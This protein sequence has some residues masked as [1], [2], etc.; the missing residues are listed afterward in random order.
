MDSPTKKYYFIAS[1]NETDEARG[2]F[3]RLV[4]HLYDLDGHLLSEVDTGVGRSDTNSW[5]FGWDRS[6]DTIIIWS[7]DKGNRAYKINDHQL[8]TI[9][10]NNEINKRAEE[11]KQKLLKG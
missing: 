10:L 7:S 8:R 5:T 3:G 9:E 1:V 11:L 4:I 6:R 2:D